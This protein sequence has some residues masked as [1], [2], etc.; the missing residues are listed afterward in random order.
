MI[1][2]SAYEHKP[3]IAQLGLSSPFL[4]LSPPIDLP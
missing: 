1:I 3:N 2:T 4:P